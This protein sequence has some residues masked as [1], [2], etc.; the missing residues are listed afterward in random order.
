[1]FKSIFKKQF[2]LFTSVIVISFILLGAVLI[3]IFSNYFRSQKENILIEQGMKISKLYEEA[4]YLSSPG[5]GY[6]TLYEIN[7]NNKVQ[8]LYEYLNSSYFIT[9][10]DFRV[11]V[12][13]PNLKYLY[14]H[15]LDISSIDS[16]DN[17]YSNNYIS[18]DGF[19]DN[20]LEE[21]MLIIGYPITVNGN[22]SGVIFMLSPLIELENSISEVVNKIILYMLISI[23]IT[24]ILIYILSKR[25][26]EP[27]R[28]MN[29]VAQNISMNNDFEKRIEVISNDEI[30]QLAQS[31]NQ[32]AENLDRQEKIRQ[33]FIA[34]ISHDIRSPLTSMKG[35]LQAILDGTIPKEKQ[36]N[37]LKIVLEECSRL[38]KLA[39]DMLDINRI[40]FLK[41]IDLN[42]Q[43]FNLNDLIQSTVNKFEN[44]ISK[45]NIKLIVNFAS[46]KSLVNADYEKIQRVIYNLLDN[47]LKFTQD[48]GKITINTKESF[49]KIYVSIADN[50]KGLSKKDA[51][52]IFD[53]FYKADISRGEYKQGSGLGLAI[54][55][56]FIKAHN[57]NII[58]KTEENKGCEFIF[59]LKLEKSD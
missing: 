32:M 19:L 42:L 35:F 29:I 23:F 40:D 47:A 21:R 5:S 36:E 33:E 20:S 46:S 55:K 8:N 50:G 13:S 53:R 22:L 37:Y 11:I 2:F 45:K 52:R 57:E 58:V 48:Y 12:T 25:I 17:L 3:N 51:E 24:F 10:S 34:N 9:D 41:N 15:K 1:M 43:I 27:L 7:I 28:Q 44:T 49:P 26:T 18:M 38:T 6:R 31:F 16:I 59:A 56:E 39:N 30:G 54:V 14:N 4:I